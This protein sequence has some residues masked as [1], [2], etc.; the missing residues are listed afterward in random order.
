[1]PN[2][3]L[4]DGYFYLHLKPIKYAYNIT[5]TSVDIAQYEIIYA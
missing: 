5:L 2:N 4:R 3:D 1:M